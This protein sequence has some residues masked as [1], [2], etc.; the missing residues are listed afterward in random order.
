MLA[1][2]ARSACWL[3]LCLTIAGCNG[4]GKLN[5][6]GVVKHPD[7][8]VP[9]GMGPSYVGFYPADPN[10]PKAK[11]ASA[12]I[13]AETGAFT[14]YTVKPGDGAFPGKYKVIFKVDAAYPP[15]ANGASSLVPVEYNDPDTTPLTA[16]ISSSQTHFPFEVPKRTPGGKK[17]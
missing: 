16:E 13:D 10:D 6:T 7:G 17:K 2:V 9:K 11:G 14:L 15:K 8:S 3:A 5:V 4:E 12:S 1:R